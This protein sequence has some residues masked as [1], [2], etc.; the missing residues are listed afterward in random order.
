LLLEA[1]HPWLPI[2]RPW[3]LEIAIVFI[4]RGGGR[5][6]LFLGH[7]L[8]IMILRMLEFAPLDLNASGATYT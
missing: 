4:W 1:W 5:G 3:R 7:N 8:I 2:Q 6:H